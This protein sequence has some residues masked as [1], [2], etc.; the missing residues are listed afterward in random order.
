MI[1]TK[2][3]TITKEYLDKIRRFTAIRPGETFVYVPKAFRELPGELRSRFT[4][5]PI[6]GEDALKFSDSMRGNVCIEAG[7]NTAVS[8][9]R[10]EYTINVVK[11]GL[12][13]WDNFYDLKGD[14]IE[15][16]P[17]DFQNLSILLLEELCDAIVSRA[18]LT[19]EEVLGLR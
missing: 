15:Y 12:V 8:V 14:V 7:G 9:K 2:H 17:D 5:R 16:I 3:V 18:S 11:R 4:L 13:R 10:G 1:E 19:E 6:S